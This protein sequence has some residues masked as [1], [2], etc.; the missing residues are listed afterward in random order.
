MSDSIEIENYK[1]RV[2]RAGD[3]YKKSIDAA[4][5]EIKKGVAELKKLGVEDPLAEISSLLK[6]KDKQKQ[7]IAKR[8]DAQKAVI[9]QAGLDLNTQLV[10]LVAPGSAPPKELQTLPGWLENLLKDVTIKLTK[11]LKAKVKIKPK[12]D[13]KW[14][15]SEIGLDVTWNW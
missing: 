12:Y 3:D 13:K 11:N 2:L 5:A 1:A 10:V 15:L 14:K 8:I 7:A 9:D 6:D 4:E